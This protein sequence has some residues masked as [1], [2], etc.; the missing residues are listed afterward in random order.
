[1]PVFSR[2]GCDISLLLPMPLPW[3][4]HRIWP[5]V[6]NTRRVPGDSVGHP[7]AWGCHFVFRAFSGFA[8]VAAGHC[9][10][11]FLMI[12]TTTITT[13]KSLSPLTLGKYRIAACP[14]PLPCGRFAAQVSIAS[15]RGSASTA[16]VM[17]FVDDFSTH[18]AAAKYAV[19]QGI[20][21]VNDTLRIQ[22]RPTVA[23]QMPS[24]QICI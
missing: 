12:H 17:R 9:P 21:W 1:M 3:L 20:D 11:M 10:L 16:R 5:G 24:P 15:G 18:D 4:V 22:A 13:T 8:A 6:P 23:A 2:R 14:R 19:A 7:G